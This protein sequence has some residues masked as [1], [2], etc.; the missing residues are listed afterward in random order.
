M[1]CC[2]VRQLPESS[3]AQLLLVSDKGTGTVRQGGSNY[4]DL[5]T[6]YTGAGSHSVKYPNI[7]S[8]ISIVSFGNYGPRLCVRTPRGDLVIPQLLPATFDSS[9]HRRATLPFDPT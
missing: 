4:L 9:R 2:V 3:A 7:Y 6:I 5:T 1:N 8:I